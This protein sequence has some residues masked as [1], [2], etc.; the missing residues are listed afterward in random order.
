MFRRLLIAFYLFY[1]D[2]ALTG[3]D[4]RLLATVS[5]KSQRSVFP[6]EE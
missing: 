2:L 5:V 4:Q 6:T 1:Y 3:F